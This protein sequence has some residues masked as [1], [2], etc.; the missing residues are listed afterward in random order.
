M[1]T[2]THTCTVM[3]KVKAD[4]FEVE[5]ERVVLAA[6]LIVS[7]R[8]PELGCENIILSADGVVAVGGVFNGGWFANVKDDVRFLQ[9]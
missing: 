2:H 8:Q 6:A 7:P 5:G 9:E 3:I 1:H 4:R